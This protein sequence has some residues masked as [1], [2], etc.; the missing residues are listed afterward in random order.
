MCASL[1]PGGEPGDCQGACGQTTLYDNL[2]I[3]YGCDKQAF[4]RIFLARA[5]IYHMVS[6]LVYY[7]HTIGFVLEKLLSKTDSLTFNLHILE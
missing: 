5:E 6:L 3:K 4:M 2:D 1:I 7:A